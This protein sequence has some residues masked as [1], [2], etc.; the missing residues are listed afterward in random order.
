VIAA[1]AVNGIV[2]QTV[3]TIDSGFTIGAS[4]V[5]PASGNNMGAAAYLVQGSVAQL[6]PTWSWTAANLGIGATMLNFIAGESAF[7]GLAR[8]RTISV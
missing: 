1:L 5:N 4:V 8:L 3:P 6:A 7:R 2:G